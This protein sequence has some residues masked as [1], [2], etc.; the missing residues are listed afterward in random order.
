MNADHYSIFQWKRGGK[1][2]RSIRGFLEN[3]LASVLP[4]SGAD[5][6]ATA[7]RAPVNDDLAESLYRVSEDEVGGMCED[8][9]KFSNDDSRQQLTF[10]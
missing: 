2:S 6:S 3:I 10:E 9:E 8:E 4:A 7:S 1:M 5:T